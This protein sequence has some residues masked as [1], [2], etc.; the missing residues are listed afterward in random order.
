MR[1]STETAAASPVLPLAEKPFTAIERMFLFDTVSH[2]V[3]DPAESPTA[4]FLY[5]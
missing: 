3:I 4:R 2:S 5:G 1:E